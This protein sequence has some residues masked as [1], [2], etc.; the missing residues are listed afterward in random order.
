MNS[1]KVITDLSVIQYH[2]NGR[3]KSYTLQAQREVENRKQKEHRT[4]HNEAE[5]SVLVEQDRRS[6]RQK[7][8]DNRSNECIICGNQTFRKYSKFYRLCETGRAKLFLRATKFNMDAVVTN[9]SIFYKPDDLFEA[10]IMS[11]KLC[12]NR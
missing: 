2:S 5:S 10:D 12:T 8:N 1:W 6:R 4:E 11:H 3:Y 7:S 9:V